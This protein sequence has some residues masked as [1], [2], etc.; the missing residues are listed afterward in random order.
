MIVLDGKRAAEKIIQELQ[1]KVSKRS[2]PPP[3][4]AAILVGGDPASSIYVK[5][6]MKA[7]ERAGFYSELKKF[8]SDV[9]K[10]ELEEAI[11]SLNQRADIHG[12]L[13][14]LPLP[15]SLNKEEVLS[16]LD[17]RKDP[18]GLTMENKALLWAGQPRVVPCT[19][20]GI[21]D[22]MD[23]YAV[24]FYRRHAVVVGRS[25]IVGLPLSRHL[26]AFDATVTICHS[27]TQFLSEICQRADIVIVCAGKKHLL[28][29]KDFRVGATVVDVGIHRDENGKLTGDVLTDGLEDHLFA[30]S[31][32]PGG[33]GPM[34]I[35]SL[36]QNTFCLSE[37]YHSWPSDFS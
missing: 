16:W 7:C 9:S 17:P 4:L 2:A 6:K 11:K 20:K 27:K 25:Q 5:N 21:I 37:L 3:G 33:V 29:K 1:L 13:V 30:L 23:H 14:Q 32:V 22:L 24:P 34:T 28:S 19:P 36:L 15:P 18:D 26:L 12:I 10:Q 35:A 8:S 31:C